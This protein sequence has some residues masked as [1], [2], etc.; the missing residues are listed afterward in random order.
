M[1]MTDR[2]LEAKLA[3]AERARDQ[4]IAAARKECDKAVARAF[5]AQKKAW[6]VYLKAKSAA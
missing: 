2:A 1:A 6:E 4:A 3:A 5:A